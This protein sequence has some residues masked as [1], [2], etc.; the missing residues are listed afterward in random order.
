MPLE[1]SKRWPGGLGSN[2][3]AGN[4]GPELALWSGS[5][6]ICDIGLVLYLLEDPV[7]RE[8]GYVSW[9]FPEPV[10]VINSFR[11]GAE[12]SMQAWQQD[13]GQVPVRTGMV[14]GGQGNAASCRMLIGAAQS[15]RHRHHKLLA[16][17]PGFLC[18]CKLVSTGQKPLHLHL[19]NYRGTDW[20]SAGYTAVWE[21]Q[22]W[23]QW[24]WEAYPSGDTGFLPS[25]SL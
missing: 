8:L 21:I 22:Q 6:C 18:S 16:S 10:E 11:C 14:G 13:E 9:N 12:L 17:G 20:V 19:A 7:W 4:L 3:C 5:T 1:S 2:G 25:G 15:P 24:P 23:I